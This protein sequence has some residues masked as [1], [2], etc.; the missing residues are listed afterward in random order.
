[1][2]SKRKNKKEIDEKKWRKREAAWAWPGL[3][4]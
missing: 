1:M 3:L 4:S 2:R